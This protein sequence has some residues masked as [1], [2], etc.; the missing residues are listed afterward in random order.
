MN[1][2]YSRILDRWNQF[3]EE[4]SESDVRG[5]FRHFVGE[6]P[7]A[8]LDSEGM[9]QAIYQAY[10]RFRERWQKFMEVYGGDFEAKSVYRQLIYEPHPEL[11]AA[12]IGEGLFWKV[13]AE[14]L[15]LIEEYDLD[16]E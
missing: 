15:E 16:E 6:D 14:A 11:D 4:E 1:E 10:C 12:T 2:E 8:E 9:A 7:P 13:G 5:L 3:V